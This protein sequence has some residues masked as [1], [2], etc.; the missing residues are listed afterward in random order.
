[1]KQWV[2]VFIRKWTVSPCETEALSLKLQASNDGAGNH[3]FHKS[4]NRKLCSF[5]CRGKMRWLL[6]CFDVWNFWTGH[7]SA[8]P[9]KTLTSKSHCTAWLP[10]RCL[11]VCLSSHTGWDLHTG[12]PNIHH[13]QETAVAWNDTVSARHCICFTWGQKNTFFLIADLDCH[14][15]LEGI[16]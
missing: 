14:M 15:D 11:R 4:S 12:L 2:G 8:N 9:R 3:S 10:A 5:P 6:T 16:R 13:V 7:L 1:M